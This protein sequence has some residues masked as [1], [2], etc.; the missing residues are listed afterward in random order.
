MRTVIAER[1][2]LGYTVVFV[3]VVLIALVAS[4]PLVPG[5]RRRGS[6][7]QVCGAWFA[8]RRV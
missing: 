5:E 8:F 4:V 7:V 3:R 2:G 1:L 6:R